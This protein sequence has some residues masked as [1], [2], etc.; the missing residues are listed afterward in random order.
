V[1]EH[2]EADFTHSLCPECRKRLYPELEY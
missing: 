1:E 2:S